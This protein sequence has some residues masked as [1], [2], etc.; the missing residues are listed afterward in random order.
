MTRVL[1]TNPATGE[2]TPV[3][4]D[5]SNG[6]DVAAATAAAAT[7]APAFAAF[8]LSERATLLES[9]ASALEEDASVLVATADRETALGETRLAGELRRTCFQFRFFAGVVRDGAFLEASVDHARDTPM[10]P[11]PDLRRQLEPL[12]PVAVFGASNFPLAFSVPGGDTASALAAGCPVVVKAHPA[13]PATSQ[14]AFAAIERALRAG[15]APPGTLGLV[16][17]LRAGVDLVED[18]LVT[19]VGF[20]GSYGAGRALFD[21]ALARAPPIPF[22]GQHGSVNPLVV[23]ARAAAARAASIGE[24]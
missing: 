3:G 24:G 12:G 9:V 16:Y 14:R 21:R 10:G 15:G 18:P 5:E 19:A 4:V 7:A 2:A 1:S 8:D 6:A 11:L 23:T 17:G 22:Y 13:H 20:T